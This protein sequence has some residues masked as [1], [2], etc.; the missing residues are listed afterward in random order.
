M[1]HDMLEEMPTP[2]GVEYNVCSPVFVPT[3]LLQFG[4]SALGTTGNQKGFADG[5]TLYRE[6]NRAKASPRQRALYR[7]P[8]S[9][10][11]NALGKRPLCQ[12]RGSRQRVAGPNGTWHRPLCRVPCRQALGKGVTFAECRRPR[13]RVPRGWLR[14][15][16]QQHLCWM[17][18]LG[19]ARLSWTV[20]NSFAECQTDQAFAKSQLTTKNLFLKKDN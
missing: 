17:P 12:E 10:Q 6:P 5:Q 16:Q 9:R 13:Q 3:K 15:G 1:N 7:V 19:K 4:K 20:K 11:R 14:A 8:N 18:A 2:E